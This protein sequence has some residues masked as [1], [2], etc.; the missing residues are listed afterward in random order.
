MAEHTRDTANSQSDKTKEMLA[1]VLEE[2]MREMHEMRITINNL[3]SEPA[4]AREEI[5]SFTEKNKEAE[6]QIII[7]TEGGYVALEGNASVPET[8]VKILRRSSEV[9]NTVRKVAMQAATSQ[10]AARCT[11]QLLERKGSVVVVGIKE[12][13]GSNKQEL[14]SKDREAVHGILKGLH[15]EGTEQNIEKVFRLGW[16]NKDRNRL[17]KVV[18]ANEIMKE[19]ILERK[20]HLQ[21]VEEYKK[22]KKHI[23]ACKELLHISQG[24]K[25]VKNFEPSLD[26]YCN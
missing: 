26:T 2:F 5:K 16:C 13:E 3:Q 4:S 22:N 20:S 19:V 1:Q 10:K 24:R 18:F 17:V 8:F 12:Q 25:K 6:H 21:T 7:Q 23:N 11:S 15:M 14:N 9:I